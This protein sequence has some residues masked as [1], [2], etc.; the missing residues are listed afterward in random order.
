MKEIILTIVVLLLT[1]C[2]ATPPDPVV[3][4]PPP[5]CKSD[6]Q[7]DVMWSA[8]QDWVSRIGRMQVAHVMP[9]SIV[10]FPGVLTDR[11]TMSGTVIKKP[12]EGGSYEL[13]AQ[14]KCLDRQLPC[15][16]LEHSGV[17]LFNTMVTAAGQ[18]L[19]H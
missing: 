8:A 6:T 3:S 10:T 4:I 7:C 2:L 19:E 14:F 13:A 12:I 18:G 11:T 5:V 16:Q 15:E 1:G 9:D 17:N